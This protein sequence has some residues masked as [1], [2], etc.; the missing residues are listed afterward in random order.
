MTDILSVADAAKEL[1]EI[2]ISSPYTQ[3][4]KIFGSNIGQ[5]C[6]IVCLNMRTGFAF[7]F[8]LI[9]RHSLEIK[10]TRKVP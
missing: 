6:C 9:G 4:R 5:V 7:L 3:R 2:L 1:G 10:K 8:V